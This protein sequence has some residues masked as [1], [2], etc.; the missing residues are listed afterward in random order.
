M[1]TRT[2]R[3]IGRLLVTVAVATLAGCGGG[4]SGGGGSSPP[5][6]TLSAISVTPAGVHLTTGRQRQLTATGLYSDAGLHD[7]TSFVTWSTSDAA[8]VA[9]SAGGLTTGGATPGAASIT[10]SLGLVS[11]NTVVTLDPPLV[12]SVSVPRTGATSCYDGVGNSVS[13]AGS[14]Q[15][16]ALQ[17]GVA[18]PSPRF[19]DNADG[20]VTDALTGLQWLKNADCKGSSYPVYDVGGTPYGYVDWDDALGFV[21]SVNTGVASAC[22]A[23]HS[24]WRLPNV[25]ELHTLLGATPN[26]TGLPQPGVFTNVAQFHEYWTSTYR[27][28]ISVSGTVA[29]YAPSRFA[30]VWPVRTDPAVPAPPAAVPRTGLALCYSP[31]G[32]GTIPCAGTGQ[33][34]DLARG[35]A[36]PEPRFVDRGDGSIEDH[37]TGL[38]WLANANCFGAVDWLP[39]LSAA[40]GLASGACG[41]SDGSL[42]GDWRLP[43]RKELHS[44]V[45]Y[46]QTL[47]MIP[48]GSPFNSVAAAN[49]HSST[50]CAPGLLTSGEVTVHM[51]NGYET[52]SYKQTMNGNVP[53]PAYV[54]PVRGGP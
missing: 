26:A 13:C 42:P 6:P 44:L 41:L 24:D 30:W 1:Q 45:D 4:G 19:V 20:T 54:W 10:A 34:A 22:A 35:V 9:V 50:T 17:K 40:N 15:D 21:A 33:D 23:G 28:T 31:A 52:C 18:W 27:W 3:S 8:R 5:A 51:G 43:N 53:Q 49:Y 36:W 32:T 37:L 7:V 48:A 16:G 46:S 11:G 25:N 47:P 29:S 38:V 12:G 14:G 39:A 2:A